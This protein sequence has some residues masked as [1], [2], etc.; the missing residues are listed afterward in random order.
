MPKKVLFVIIDALSTNVI[1][2]AWRNGQLPNL[3]KLVELGWHRH[4]TAVFPSITPAATASLI[5]GCYPAEHKISGAYWYD[6][7][8]EC[9]NY[10]GADLEVIMREG[11]GTYL[12]DFQIRLNHERLQAPT[13]YQQVEREGLTAACLNFMWFRGDVPHEFQTPFLFKLIPDLSPAERVN[14]PKICYLGDFA[15]TPLPQSGQKLEGPGGAL[16]K[17]GMGDET[18]S[19]FLRQLC[20]AGLPDLT[21]AY[22]P[23]NDFKSHAE[24]PTEAL[25]AVEDIDQTLG[26]IFEQFGG[27]EA[28]L[29][30][31][32]IVVTGDHSQSPLSKD[33]P[34]INLDEVLTDFPLVPAGTTWQTDEDVMVC[35]NLR[36]AQIYFRRPHH[37]DDEHLRQV[38]RSLKQCPQ[39]DQILWRNGSEG[40]WVYHIQSPY[41]EPLVFSSDASRFSKSARD[42]YGNTWSWDGELTVVDGKTNADG[43]LEFRDYPNAFERIANAFFEQTGDVWITASPGWEFVVPGVN[44]HPG[45]SHGTLHADD[46][47]SP[48]IVAGAPA[49]FAFPEHPRSVDVAGICCRLL[50]IKP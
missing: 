11:I 35:T 7:E 23:D 33:D 17:F 36:S 15:Q 30:E 9:I 1:E 5:T 47:T 31:V 49:E 21:V 12:R 14:G 27:V 44:P 4:S 46:S 37:D 16:H 19:A 18:T 10:F 42:V 50:G 8:A 13:L 45:G 24:G 26:Q 48:L 43:V 29:E 6:R 40:D 20:E 25:P 39:I 41:C 2:D 32:A 38:V 28:M 34:G 22:F 3:S